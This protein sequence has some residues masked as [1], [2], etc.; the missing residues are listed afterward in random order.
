LLV[1]FLKI[2]LIFIFIISNVSASSLNNCK[3]DNREGSPCVAIHKTSNTSEY[4]EKGVF[5]KIITREEI[6]KNGA[7]DVVDILNMIDGIDVKQNGQ[8]GQLTSLFTRGT[9]SNHTLV[10]LNGIAI[11]DQSTTQ[12]LHNFGQDFAQTIQ[13]VEIYKGANGAH[14]GPSAIGGA[15]NFIT[16]IDY[17]NTFSINGFNGK[18]N[19][20]NGN[21]TKITNDGWHLNVKG[22]TLKSKTGSS[23]YSGLAS[24]EDDSTK[25]NQINLNAKRW[26]NDNLK[27][28]S[29]LY[30]RRT[31]SNYDASTSDAS[32]FGDDNMY[33]LQTSLSQIT[34]NS[35][36]LI[37]F[38]YNKYDREYEES[39]YFDEYNS[40]SFVMKAE[41]KTK[42]SNKISYGYGSEFKYDSGNFTNNGSWSSPT[43]K[44]YV[45]N[46]SFF[47]NTG[48]KFSENLLFSLY[49]RSDKHKTT[50]RNSS[51]KLNISKFFDNFDLSVTHSTGLRN[52]SLYELYGNNGRSDS[53]KHV[54][55]PDADPEKS[56]TNELK[57]K[58][59][60]SNYFSLEN[61]FYK[62]LIKDALLYDSNFKGGSG[63]TNSKDDLKQEGIENSLVFDNKN[64]KLTFFNTISSS[65]KIDGSSQLNRPNS[66]YGILYS[67]NFF[68]ELV[69][70]FSLN[71]NY[72]HYGKVFDYAPNIS[73]VDSTDIMNL[74]LSKETHIGTLS[75]KITNLLDEKY[76][77]PHGYS[78]DGR[79]VRFGIITPF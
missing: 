44:G 58:Y 40:D 77:R 16:D 70:P 4:S 29:T 51:Y 24:L 12:G 8:R 46:L 76:Q 63:Y 39:G 61:T 23:R 65:K 27:F 14:F 59:Y 78:Q 15:I 30:S 75:L 37:I 52:P 2:I 53:Y 7:V 71:Y 6:I 55:N 66:T 10:L 19:I 74:S 34:K 72:K 18:N 11:N 45:E 64:Q 62:N 33:A 79:N 35:E 13:Q 36:N 20:L 17:K 47:A 57:I 48:Y 26:I 31:K 28:S 69:G 43:A 54:A 3:W 9:N 25:N 73:K 5:K 68:S 38:H 42:H 22:S 50:G 60:F 49:G 32:G 56:K 21:F 1:V 41:R 67:K